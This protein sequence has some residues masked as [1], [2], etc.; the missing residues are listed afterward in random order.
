MKRQTVD[1]T[2]EGGTTLLL[3]CSGLKDVD[4]ERI[5]QRLSEKVPA[6]RV[7]V[8]PDL[9]NRL[10]GITKPVL[11]SSATR[12]V[13]GL[14]TWDYS[15]PE[16]HAEA[17]KAGLDPFGVEVVDLAAYC[18][19]AKAGAHFEDK[20]VLRL[21]AAVARAR[22]F[23]GSRPESVK[24]ILSWNEKMSR[25]ALFTLPPLRYEPVAWIRQEKC[26]F[27]E[28]CR[29]CA[30]T[31]PQQALR[32]SKD[33]LMV[34]DKALCTGCGACAS[35]C[36]QTAIE[37]PGASPQQVQVELE[38]L[39]GTAPL[40]IDPRAILFVCQRSAKA[41]E[42]LTTNGGSDPQGW[43][44]VELPCVGMVSPTWILQCLSMGAAGVAVLP[45]GR[46]DCRFG[47]P[48]VVAGRVDYC[49]EVMKALGLRS[50]PVQL[51]DPDEVHEPSRLLSPPLIEKG[52]AVVKECAPSSLSNPSGTVAALLELA[53]R[54][55]TSERWLEHPF[56]PLGVVE[57][58]DGCTTCGTC[59]G[60]CPTG[61]LEIEPD[62]SD[63]S[64]TF[65]AQLC[66]GCGQCASVCPEG[67]V[68]SRPVTDLQRLSGG[69]VTLHRS[70]N[71]LCKKCGSP[72]APDG[73][74][75]KIAS[76]LGSD[77]PALATITKYCLACRGMSTDA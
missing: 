77:D 16:L 45:C 52:K 11:A 2:S 40:T 71:I 8:V 10:Q 4:L 49:R 62:Q 74:L 13:L 1:I 20:I 54:Y 67:V 51:L 55:E 37:L 18:E 34:L 46:D 59:T 36:P 38:T 26:A 33:G 30:A 6:V 68:T 48:D 53:E 24:P 73:M 76:V 66:I 75:E 14:C 64:L 65:D 72:I 28:G 9:C 3:L 29:V 5:S 25:R 41:L 61:A 50:E 47:Q 69:K 7:G 31:C 32:P 39:L 35:A 56:S 17:R 70:S 23:R 57:I 60:S 19:Q 43:L 12:L 22:A 21:Q 63:V 44:S 58:R 27:D 15:A 42:R